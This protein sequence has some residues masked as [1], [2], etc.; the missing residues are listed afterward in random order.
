MIRKLAS[1]ALVALATVSSTAQAN[2][3]IVFDY[4][5]DS[6]SFFTASRRAIMENVASVFETRITDSLGAI[7]SG[8]PNHFNILFDD[9]SSYG[10]NA[11][12]Q[13][14]ANT[15]QI[16]DFSLAANQVVIY[17]G[18]SNLG[19]STLGLGGPAGFSAGGTQSFIDSLSRGQA[20]AALAPN[21]QTDFAPWGGQISFNSSS[22]WYFDNNTATDEAFGGFDFFSVALHE[23]GHALGMGTA[24]SWDNLIV[25]GAFT[26]SKSVAL[27][28]GAVPLDGNGAHWQE[29]ITSPIAGA[30][31]FEA[32]LDPTITPGLRKRLTDLDWA[33][34]DDLGWDVAPV[35]AIPEPASWFM[36]LAGLGLLLPLARRAQKH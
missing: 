36:M 30:G 15:V 8:G 20:G 24:N 5:Y 28:A 7:I 11:H 29:G 13:F 2:I 32:A 23:T 26:G 14:V 12:N 18:A 10:L 25:G 19:G 17:L 1:T 4:S 6:S 3:D 9:P 33:G 31:S 27:H 22:N 16:N 34:L 35:A 21:Q